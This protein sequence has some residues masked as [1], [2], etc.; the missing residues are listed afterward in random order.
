MQPLAIDL[1]CGLELTQSELILRAD[2]AIKKLVA[3]GAKKPEHVSQ[4][5]GDDTPRSVALKLRLVGNL[6][7]ACLATC[8]AGGRKVW[9]FSAESADHRILEWPVRVVDFGSRW[10][11]AHEYPSLHSSRLTRTLLRA[12]ATVGTWRR[13]IE[14]VS[15]FETISPV[16]RNVRLFKSASTPGACCAWLRAISFI[17]PLGL[18]TCAAIRAK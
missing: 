3:C 16:F 4:G 1:Y 17:W 6:K 13:N 7:N 5:V 10:I 8:F 11:S 18:E 12:I 2:A 14:M 9:V 15:A